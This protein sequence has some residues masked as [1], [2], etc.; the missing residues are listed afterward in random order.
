MVVRRKSGDE[1]VDWAQV[2][3]EK[4]RLKEVQG[5]TAIILSAVRA[6][7]DLSVLRGERRASGVPCD[8][9]LCF[10]ACSRSLSVWEKTAKGCVCACVT[11]RM[12]IWFVCSFCHKSNQVGRAMCAQLCG[13]YAGC[14]V[15]GQ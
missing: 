6:V 12:F 8:P 5:G 7:T 9:S 4:Q 15:S 2:L 10:M 1:K 11:T 13:V 14:V 3:E